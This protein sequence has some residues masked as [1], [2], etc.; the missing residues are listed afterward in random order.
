MN[1]KQIQLTLTGIFN[2]L[3][4]RRKEKHA[5]FDISIHKVFQEKLKPRRGLLIP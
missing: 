4:N 5:I 1:I 2:V 3:C